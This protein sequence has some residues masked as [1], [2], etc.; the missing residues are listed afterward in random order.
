MI[1]QTFFNLKK[2][3]GFKRTMKTSQRIGMVLLVIFVAALSGLVGAYIGGSMV[4]ADLQTIP[5]E[6]PIATQTAELVESQVVNTSITVSSSEIDT[7]I[8]QVVEDIEPAVVTVVGTVAGTQTYFG[9]TSSYEVSGSGFVVSEEGFIITNNHVVED[10]SELY[11][12]LSDGSE[13]A[14]EIVSSDVYA[15]LAVLKVD[16]EMP[17]FR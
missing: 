2:K 6:E 16:G 11:V 13:L 5:T 7:I 1:Y 17:R 12:V 3:K 8:T 9:R 14:A 4:T 10:T 15:D